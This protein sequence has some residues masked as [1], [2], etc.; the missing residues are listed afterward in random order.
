MKLYG[1]NKHIDKYE[2]LLFVTNIEL[3][4]LAFLRERERERERD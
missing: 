2:L 1:D 3:I 4:S